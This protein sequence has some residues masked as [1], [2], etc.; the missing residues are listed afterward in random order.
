VISRRGI[1]ASPD[2]IKAIQEYPVPKTVKEVQGFLGLASYYRK[3]VQGFAQIAKPLTQLT[4][5]DKKFDWNPQC[6]NAFDEL[7]HI[8][9]TTLV[10]TY[11]DFKLPFILTTDASKIAVAAVLCQVQEGIERPIAY[12]SRQLNS[13]EQAYSASELELLPVVWA[14]KH[15]NVIYMD[16]IFW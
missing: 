15:I 14:T 2:K 3:L 5:K 6:Q 13:A 16:E 7:K 12:A 9:S 10:L 4:R 1:E 8:L 11:P